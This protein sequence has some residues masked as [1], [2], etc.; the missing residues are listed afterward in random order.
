MSEENTRKNENERIGNPEVAEDDY[1]IAPCD[2]RIWKNLWPEANQKQ[3][4]RFYRCCERSPRSDGSRLVAWATR[5]G[6]DNISANCG[7]RIRG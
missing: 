6:K 5:F 4:T 1:Q 2:L 3:F 7:S